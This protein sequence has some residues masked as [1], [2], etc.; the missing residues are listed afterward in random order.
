MHTVN[1]NVFVVGWRVAISR[2]SSTPTSGEWAT[3]FTGTPPVYCWFDQSVNVDSGMGK[4][5]NSTG[6]SKQLF[7]TGHPGV[8]R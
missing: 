5:L 8:A 2:I 1:I 3:M 6:H 4:E 7:L